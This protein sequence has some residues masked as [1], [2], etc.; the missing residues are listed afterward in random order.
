M[1]VCVGGMGWGQ[2]RNRERE[3]ESDC[4]LDN[5]ICANAYMWSYICVYMHV[6]VCMCL[7]VYGSNSY[8]IVAL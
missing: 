1:F 3:R 7:C 8:E 4:V 5:V 2:E 6:Y